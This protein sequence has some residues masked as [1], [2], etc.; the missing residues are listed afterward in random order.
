MRLSITSPKNV[1]GHSRQGMLCTENNEK[2]SE[3]D[4]SRQRQNENSS[5]SH[6]QPHVYIVY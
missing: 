4:S 6:V 3:R 1:G 2:L 5:S